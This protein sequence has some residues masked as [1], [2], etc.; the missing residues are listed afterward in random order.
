MRLRAIGLLPLILGLAACGQGPQARSV[1]APVATATLASQNMLGLAQPAMSHDLF[2]Y[3]GFGPPVLL[4]PDYMGSHTDLTYIGSMLASLDY[5]PY[6][7]D[8]QPGD[9]SVARTAQVVAQAVDEVL[10]KQN[11]SRILLLGDGMGGLDARYY[12][13]FLGGSA[14]VEALVTVCTPNEGTLAAHLD[15]GAAATDMLPGSELITSLYETQETVPT[16]AIHSSTDLSVLPPSNADL[17]HG[18]NAALC[19]MTHAT[20]RSSKAILPYLQA[21]FGNYQD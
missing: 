13:D 4:I 10:A 6:A 3:Y 21:F 19:C 14:K 5:A 16:L 12:D 11:A 15:H 9:A 7:V 18:T 2:D 20:L 8:I 17:P 1:V